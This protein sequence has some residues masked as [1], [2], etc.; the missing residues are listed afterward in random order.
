MST[1]MGEGPQQPNQAAVMMQYDAMKKS[2]A[3]A[4]LLWFFLGHF[5]AHRL[6]M[7]R[8]GSGIG[9]ALLFWISVFLFVFLI[10]IPGVVAWFIW[11]VVDA[12]LIGSWLTEHNMR[13][14][15]KL[16]R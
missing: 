5:G 12:F 15:A 14:A 7:S 10:G 1:P 13:L 3:V 2:P 6:Y 11:W 16:N 9:M 8:V 4:Y